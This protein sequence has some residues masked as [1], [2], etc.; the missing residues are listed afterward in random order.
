[1]STGDSTRLR[2][3]VALAL[4]HRQAVLALELSP[5]ATVGA[6]LLA[7]Q[8]LAEAAGLGSGAGFDW[9][10]GAVGIFGLGCARSQ[11]LQDGDRV[12]LYRALPTDPK[13][14]RRRRA[15]GSG[16]RRGH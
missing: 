16:P 10:R 8:P 11:L 3:S 5:G 7:A 15:R 1:M 9:E 4:P 2:V 12:E 14:N 6:A 13:E